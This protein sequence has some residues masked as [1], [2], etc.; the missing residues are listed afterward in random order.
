VTAPLD[1]GGLLRE[2]HGAGVKHVLIGGLAVNAH[3][4][5]RSTKDIDICPA[6]DRGNLARLATL[7]RRLG[8]RQLG[9]G[10][11]GFASQ[12]LPFDPTR[13]DDLA[14][15]GNFRLDTPL[16][17]LDIM[18]WIAGIEGD[19]AYGTLASD[20]RTATA[21]GIEL[22]VCSLAALRVMKRAAGRPQ[23]LQD[24]ADLETAHPEPS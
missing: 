13:A 5:I 3:G 16:G 19:S 2:L 12:E 11:G 20:A 15:G 8:V 21:F 14:Q 6:P 9:V 1:P 23:D 22:Q 4:V 18:Q 17:V 24:L 10:D 7:L